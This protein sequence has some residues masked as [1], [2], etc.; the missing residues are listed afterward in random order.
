[1]NNAESP[2]SHVLETITGRGS[3][4]QVITK[5]ESIRK[6]NAAIAENESNIG[7]L[8]SCKGHCEKNASLREAKKEE[9]TLMATTRYG[10]RCLENLLVNRYLECGDSFYKLGLGCAKSVE[11]HNEHLAKWSDS[12][13]WV[14]NWILKEEKRLKDSLVNWQNE[15]DAQKA[16][17]ELLT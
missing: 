5:Q 13:K 7:L 4:Y 17:L 2:D 10:L 16:G 12:E 8:K 6:L 9:G 14:E 1:M 11:A 15:L 3:L